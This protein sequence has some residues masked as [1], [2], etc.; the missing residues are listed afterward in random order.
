MLFSGIV[1]AVQPY[2]F[3][4]TVSSYDLLPAAASGL[5]GLWLPYLQIV[6]GLCIGFGLAERVALGTAA[7]LFAAF[8]LAQL[9]VLM[10]GMEIDC[11]C[12]GFV[13]S[14]I[15]VFSVSLPILL[16]GAC[17]FRLWWE[18]TT[19]IPAN[20]GAEAMT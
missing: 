2:Y 5:A 9:S 4:H 17:I 15:S 3:I 11:G 20:L 18:R 14:E 1:H 19:A 7:L 16:L 13:A 8:A 6:L 12:F 10:R